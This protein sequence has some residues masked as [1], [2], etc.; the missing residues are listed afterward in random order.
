MFVLRVQGLLLFEAEELIGKV[1]QTLEDHNLATP[2]VNVTGRDRVTI[3][4]SFDS[5]ED[6]EFVATILK[7]AVVNRAVAE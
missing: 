3:E 6:A 4:L 2:E 5:R 1:W 7:V